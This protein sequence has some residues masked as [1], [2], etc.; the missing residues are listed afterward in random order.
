MNKGRGLSDGHVVEGADRLL[1]R[2]Y[3]GWGDLSSLVDINVKT[4]S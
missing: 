3:A 4:R 2:F 1:C